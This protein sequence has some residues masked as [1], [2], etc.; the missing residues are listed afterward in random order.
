MALPDPVAN[1]RRAAARRRK[2]GAGAACALCGTSDPFALVLHEHHVSLAG[3]DPMAVC[4]LCLNCHAIVQERLRRIG[5]VEW[6]PSPTNPLERVSD[7]LLSEAD[8]LRALADSRERDARELAT[9]ARRLEQR[10]V[11]LA[12]D[13]RRLS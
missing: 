10:G 1:D 4:V 8:F 6:E 7:K 5:I 12:T 9:M 2:L 13:E 11:E 3:N